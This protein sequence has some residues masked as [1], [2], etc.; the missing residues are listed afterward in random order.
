MVR[1]T[2]QHS[3]NIF[4]LKQFTIVAISG[5]AVITLSRLFA[6]IFVYQLLGVIHSPA[7]EVADSN[8]LGIRRSP[9]TGQIVYARNAAC[10]NGANIDPVAG[11]ITLQD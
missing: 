3:V 7:I 5:H 9:N 11:P 4:V 8:D 1:G 2:D 10:P 6:V